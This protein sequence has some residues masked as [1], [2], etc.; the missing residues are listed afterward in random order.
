MYRSSDFH[1]LRILFNH[2]PDE[3]IQR[4]FYW[5]IQ[6]QKDFIDV[7]FDFIIFCHRDIFTEK[8]Y[9][10]CTKQYETSFKTLVSILLS[11]NLY[12][13]IICYFSHESRGKIKEIKL[14]SSK[15]YNGLN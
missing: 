4:L 2:N 9:Y 6:K 10:T 12:E 14:F 13:K 3:W 11:E 1:P 7:S 5:A 15:T 8:H